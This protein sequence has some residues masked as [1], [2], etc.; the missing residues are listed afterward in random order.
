MTSRHADDGSHAAAT[1]T[2]RSSASRRPRDRRGGAACPVVHICTIIMGSPHA[3]AADAL[4]D[5]RQQPDVSRLPRD[6]RADRSRRPIDQCRLRLHHDAEEAAGG[7]PSRL[8]RRL[9]RSRGG[10]LPGPDRR[11]LQGQP[12]ADA[13]RSQGSDPVGARGLR[14]DGRADPD[15]RRLRSRR[16]DRGAGPSGRGGRVR[17]RHRHR[18]QGL[19][20]ARRRRHPRLQPQGRR[21]LVRRRRSEG[22]VRRAAVAGGRRAGASWATP[23]TTSKACRGSARR[24]RGISSPPSARSMPC[25]S[26]ARK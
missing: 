3:R 14:G 6:P 24:A 2:R 7:S 13:A 8:H 16:R 19:L 21:R 22:E 25:S 20:P 10:D 18:R 15:Q 26:A 9:V 23:A 17:G 4:P 5:R 1:R 12:R 11:R